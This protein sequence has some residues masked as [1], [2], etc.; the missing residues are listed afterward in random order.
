MLVI[1]SCEIGPRELESHFLLCHSLAR[2]GFKCLLLYDQ[3]ARALVRHLA[4][5][6]QPHILIDKSS[7]VSCLPKRIA[8]TKQVDRSLAFVITQESFINL[9]DNPNSLLQ[10]GL[11]KYLD[12]SAFGVLDGFFTF[13]IHSAET[14]AKIHP[15]F[16][17]LIHGFGNPRTD[18]LRPEF[19]FFYQDDVDALTTIYDDYVLYCDSH[20]LPELLSDRTG[21][22]LKVPAKWNHDPEFVNS[23]T[24]FRS[25]LHAYNRSYH[26]LCVEALKSVALSLPSR[27]FI[28]RPH[29]LNKPSY[30]STQ[31]QD[32]NNIHVV[33]HLPVEPW[34]LASQAVMTDGCTTGIQALIADKPSISLDFHP[35]PDTLPSAVSKFSAHSASTSAELLDLLKS[36]PFIPKFNGQLSELVSFDGLATTRIVDYIS[37]AAQHVGMPPCREIDINTINFFNLDASLAGPNPSTTHWKWQA[38]SLK[39][40]E[41]K[42][43]LLNSHFRASIN[44]RN[45]GFNSFAF[46]N[47]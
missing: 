24:N 46:F 17:E 21:T 20:S 3:Y 45:V 43:S 31:F 37:N 35:R 25:E 44:F 34:I 29:P 42:V 36:S 22:A 27:H 38:T 23:F 33:Y 47:S 11:Y 10:L 9:S 40:F 8:V 39:R 2:R 28:V 26:P 7:S 18:L 19:S 30:W 16:N 5:L 41:R 15:K 4:K 14:L 13:G 32:I 6:N 1:V 12:P